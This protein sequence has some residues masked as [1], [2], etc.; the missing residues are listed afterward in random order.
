MH[1]AFQNLENA[2]NALRNAVKSGSQ[3]DM[4][5]SYEGVQKA[6]QGVELMMAMKNMLSKIID[7]IIDNIKRIGQ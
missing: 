5:K 4:M 7:E 2:Q 1:G 3:E 6:H